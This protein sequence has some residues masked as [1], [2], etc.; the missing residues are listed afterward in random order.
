L[1]EYRAVTAFF[2]VIIMIL[3]FAPTRMTIIPGNSATISTEPN[4]IM[5]TAAYTPHAPIVITTDEDFATQM[6]PGE[7]KAKNPYVIEGLNITTS[8]ICIN[9]TGTNVFFEIRNCLL[10]SSTSSTSAAILFDSLKYGSVI[11]CNIYNHFYGLYVSQASHCDAFDNDV[12]DCAR[13]FEMY[14]SETSTFINNVVNRSGPSHP[15]GHGF[16]LENCLSCTFINNTVTDSSGNGYSIYTCYS[17]TFVNN[18]VAKTVLGPVCIYGFEVTTSDSCIF[19]N[20]TVSQASIGFKIVLC[21]LCTL[22][23]NT[24][25]SSVDGLGFGYGFFIDSSRSCILS[26]NRASNNSAQG[27]YI[28]Q[29]T[30]ITLDNNTASYN[31]NAGFF[32]DGALSC[33]L[34]K[35][36]ASYNSLTYSIYGGFHL[37]DC[38]NCTLADN[39]ATRNYSDNF[40]LNR[41]DNCLLTGNI[42]TGW[43]TLY[44]DGFHLS[45]SHACTL[46]SNIATG[47]KDY[48]FYLDHSYLCILHNNNAD[49]NTKTGFFL[50][51]SN[52]CTILGNTAYSNTIGGFVLS[53]SINCTL[54][55]NVAALSS[56]GISI[57]YSSDNKLFLNWIGPNVLNAGD[58]Y[59]INTWDDGVSQGNHW[60]DY[61]G[62]GVY[63]VSGP[64]GSGDRYPSG[65]EPYIDHPV[66]FQ[67][68]EGSTAHSITWHPSSLHPSS[69][70]LYITTPT[71]ML[72]GMGPWDGSAFTISVEGLSLGAYSYNLVVY[73]TTGNSTS[74]TVVVTVVDNTPPTIN[75]PPDL[76]YE[77]GTTEYTIVWTPQD[78]HLDVYTITCNQTPISGVWDGTSITVSVDGLALG[79]YNYSL[80]INDTSGNSASDT[81]FITVVDNTA[82]TMDRPVDLSYEFGTTGHMILWAPLDIHPASYLIL[83][84]GGTVS[85]GEW[86]GS[87]ISISVDG[88]ALGSY[89]YTLVVF[90][91]TGNSVLDQVIVTVTPASITTT[92]TTTTTTTTTI[93]TTSSTTTT[94]G[95]I[96]VPLGQTMLIVGAISAAFIIIIA[97]I[98]L[99]RR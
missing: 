54:A 44:S 65:M 55:E 5:T 30:R 29:S 42:A 76:V 79:I 56:C 8:G 20:N 34:S 92:A 61:G 31:T 43:A 93:P 73:D 35:N 94:E 64:S 58:A 82:P 18:T 46:I 78:L 97:I 9:V 21:V 12:T 25:S 3:S 99:R 71:G 7:G 10:N 74:D 84:D 11:D 83:L 39:F 2:L 1:K 70:E 80:V 22:T 53:Y 62:S 19:T 98:F 51:N 85:S 60:S 45:Y 47:A 77:S 37:Y 32:V 72:Y 91:T 14:A 52:D 49:S 27:F 88:L 4:V 23:E 41:S 90:D 66:D 67:Y 86:N 40:Y 17:C 33:T 36:L 63:L 16:W 24:G 50:E 6:W 59:G 28:W 69:Y 15:L 81:V 75:T 87:S 26:Y 68:E 48:G 38:Y 96:L 95:E 57:A 89:N 13:G